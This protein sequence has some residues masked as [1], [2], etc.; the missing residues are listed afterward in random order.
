MKRFLYI[1]YI[2][3]TFNVHSIC[4]AI[5]FPEYSWFME[6]VSFW[7]WLTDWLT[8]VAEPDVAEPDV[9]KPDVAKPDVAEADVAEPDIV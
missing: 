6:N 9:A 7:Y 3:Y 8:D 5:K 2:Q 4:F 1:Q